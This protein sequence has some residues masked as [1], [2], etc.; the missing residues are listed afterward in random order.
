MSE[1]MQ[2]SFEEITIETESSKPKDDP[3][4]KG[5]TIGE[6]L[7]Y[8]THAPRSEAVRKE[9]EFFK[10]MIARKVNSI[11]EAIGLVMDRGINI[12][13]YLESINFDEKLKT[14]REYAR[15]LEDD[16][17]MFGLIMLEAEFPPHRSIPIIDIPKLVQI[18][19]QEGKDHTRKLIERYFTLFVYN[20]EQIKKILKSWVEKEWLSKRNQI[21]SQAIKGHLKGYY[22]LTIP[23][24]L[25]QIE[26]VLVDGMFK[27]GATQPNKEIQ[28]PE[29]KNFL[30]KVLLDDTSVFSFEQQLE[31]F[32]VDTILAQFTRGEEIESDLSRHAI[33]HGEDTEYNTKVKSLKT[34]LVLDT[35]VEKLDELFSDMEASKSKVEKLK[36]LNNKEKSSK[37]M[38]VHKY[39]HLWNDALHVRELAREHN[40][41]WKKR[42]YVRGCVNTAWTV[43]EVCCKDA[44]NVNSLSHNFKESIKT[45][46]STQQ[47]SP[48]NWGSGTWQKVLVLKDYNVKSS[49]FELG[50][51]KIWDDLLVAEDAIK[52]ARQAIKEI[53]ANCNKSIPRWIEDDEPVGYM[54]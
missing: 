28:Y 27:L 16:T 40:E 33:M 48:L 9:T 4:K 18:Y 44:L 34:I 5:L 35:I 17:S 38:I 19:D 7:R 10:T 54:G 13:T 42:V 22:E 53:Y 43:L 2:D 51:S 8:M 24:L 6:M 14:F 46:L 15:Q 45:S 12:R 30:A 21:L 29:Q 11:Q 50:Q 1:D 23:T 3:P 47:L 25:A 39:Y 49:N 41:D 37:H 36:A 31:K 52:V 32:Y 26:G 20:E